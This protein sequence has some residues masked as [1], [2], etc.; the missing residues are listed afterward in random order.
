MV[1]TE[2]ENQ[3]SLFRSHRVWGLDRRRRRV[4]KVN[5]QP[6]PQR[7]CC[8]TVERILNQGVTNSGKLEQTQKGDIGRNTITNLDKGGADGQCHSSHKNYMAYNNWSSNKYKISLI[9]EKLNYVF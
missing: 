9:I 2:Y 7:W 6:P 5:R 3:N 1:K 4:A 8:Q